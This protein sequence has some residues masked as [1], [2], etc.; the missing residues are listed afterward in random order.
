M[1]NLVP[2]LEDVDGGI[3]PRIL[4]FR[5]L[6]ECEWSASRPVRYTPGVRA[7]G[8]LRIGGRVGPRADLDAVAKRKSPIIAFAGN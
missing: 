1:L 6:D 3:A 5:K 7:S 4:R 2:S 8:T